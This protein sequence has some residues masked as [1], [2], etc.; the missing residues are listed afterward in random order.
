M[1]V[2]QETPLGVYTTQVEWRHDTDHDG[3]IGVEEPRSAAARSFME[4][5][6][7]NRDRYVDRFELRSAVLLRVDRDRNHR[8]S[9]EE[10]RNAWIR[11]DFPY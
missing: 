3:R 9:R 8:I 7:T 11:F 10:R 2:R 4:W 1:A 5:A 6:D